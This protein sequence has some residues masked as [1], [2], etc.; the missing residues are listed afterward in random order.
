MA[1]RKP[2]PIKLT[3]DKCKVYMGPLPESVLMANIA[4]QSQHHE[5]KLK[6]NPHNALQDISLGRPH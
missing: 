2:Q 4:F 1:Q 3:P 5:L 6:A